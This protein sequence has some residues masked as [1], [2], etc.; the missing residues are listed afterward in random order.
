[1]TMHGLTK[2]SL[3]D[4]VAVV[5]GLKMPLILL[6]IGN[7]FRLVR[8]GYVYGIM[9]GEA[10]RTDGNGLRTIILL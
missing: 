1:M 9:D 10:R 6:P 7:Q 4:P 2:A 3:G 8:H 5:E